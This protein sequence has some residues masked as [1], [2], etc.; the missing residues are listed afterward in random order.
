LSNANKKDHLYDV[1]LE[2]VGDFVFNQAVVDV[3]NNMISRSV[4]G[5]A[6][7]EKMSGVLAGK[8]IQPN[9]ACYDLGCSLGT[10]IQSMLEHIEVTPVTIHGIDNSEAMVRECKKRLKRLQHHAN[11]NITCSS[12]EDVIVQNASMVVLNFSL[13]FVARDKRDAVLQ[14][15]C[16]GLVSNG[17]CIVSEKVH[18]PSG[19][20][21]QLQ[22]DLHHSFKR[23]QGYSDMEISQKRTALE[24]VLITDTIDEHVRRFNDAGFRHVYKWFQCF[25]FVSFIGIK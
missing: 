22:Q 7:I 14:K 23:L 1:P 3:F 21:E 17:I 12:I 20:E 25:N 4:P 24:N 6:A 9:T 19:D 16:D 18:F 15:V 10:T 11:L 13:Q 5:Y 2:K 8:Y